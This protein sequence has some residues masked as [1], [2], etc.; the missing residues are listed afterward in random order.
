VRGLRGAIV[1]A[2][3]AALAGAAPA[4]AQVPGL[5]GQGQQPSPP[6]LGVAQ[7]GSFRSVLAQGEGQSISATD[8][9]AYEANGTVPD[10]F[11]NQQP[12]YVGVMPA[13]AGLTTSDLDR[14]YKNTNFGSTPG[15]IGSVDTPRPGVQ[16]FRDKAY[17][18]AHVYGDTR[19]D[20]MFG[21]GY[22]AA[23]ERLFMM[24]ALRRTAEGTL[25]GLVGPSAAGGD[26]SQLTDQDFSPDELTKQ[27]NSMPQRLGALGQRAHDDIQSYVDGINARIDQVNA[28][29]A[30]LPAEYPALG[31]RPAPWTVADSAAEATLLVTQFTVSNGSEE[32]NAIMQQAFRDRFGKRWRKPYSDFREAQ[33]PEAFTVAKKPFLSDR[34]GK[35]KR[36]LSAMPDGGSLKP[37]NAIVQGPG[38]DQQ[39]AAKSKMPAWAQRLLGLRASLPPVESNAVMVTPKMSRDGKPLAAM[40]PQVSY[41]SPQI[42][43]EYELHGGG[44]DV[45][46]VAF[47]GAAPYPL[48]G[49]GID[50]AWSGT[51]ANGD[52][53]DTFVERLCNPDGSPA[54]EKSTSYVYKG[55]CIPFTMRDQQVQTPL[56]P[57]DPTTPPQTITYRTM[58][59]V[60]GPVF[61][62]GTVGG[63]PVALAKAKAVDFHELDAA[64]PFMQMAENGISDARGFMAA[65]GKFPGTE[66]W[67]Y[68]DNKSVAFQQSGRYPK[69]ARGSDVDRPYWGDGRADWQGFNPSAYTFKQIPA[70]HRPRALNPPQGFFI[71]W[72]NKEA[73]GWRKGPSEWSDGPV[74]RALILQRKLLIQRKREGG[75]VDLVGLTRAVN[76]AATTDLR[77]EEVYPW[78]RRVIG[79]AG[80]TRGKLLAL[81]DDWQRSGAQRLDAN[82][83]NVY[84]HSA[85]VALFDAWWPL[86]VKAEFQPTLGTRLFDVILKNVLSL[87]TPL[88]WDWASQVQ[89]DLRNVLGRRERG[90]HSRIYC[91]GSVALPARKRALSRARSRCRARLLSALDAAAADVAKKQGTADPSGW[92]VFATCKQTDPPSCD[93]EVPTSAGAIDTPPFPWQNRGTYHQIVELAGHR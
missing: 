11:V 1:T 47:P 91:G 13:A 27:F 73:P 58:R 15:G 22:A 53:E 81:L 26:A 24:D 67:F 55:K 45:E 87:E 30:L 52:N 88:D 92:K 83:D 90:R 21:A 36:G 9:A 29:P 77:G 32:I 82:N 37:R 51:S 38:A 40:G 93:Q 31:T 23:Q 64:V 28:N 72:N 42:F 50:F 8:L 20:V 65:F 63:K 4:A 19:S 80:G 59:S 7:F 85:A 41:Y 56:S 25:A 2:F 34:P 44:I 12:L 68:V 89:K 79:K 76:L 49:H 54:T 14:F 61:K 43:Q 17:G 86:A 71:S 84:D 66:N 48:I 46:G 10:T 18:M 3:V 62:L 74:H 33:D 35:V 6:Q 78:M 69:H 5:P 39:A 75:K 70:S 16:I 60:H 57:T